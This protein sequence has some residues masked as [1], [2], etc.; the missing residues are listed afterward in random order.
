MRD[1][2]WCICLLAGNP[3]LLG[4]RSKVGATYGD[5][6]DILQVNTCHRKR[7]NRIAVRKRNDKGINRLGQMLLI[8]IGSMPG[9]PQ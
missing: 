8:P 6:T 7:E 4:I 3:L 2:A 9:I 1:W 5:R